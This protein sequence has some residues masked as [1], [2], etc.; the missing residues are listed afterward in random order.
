MRK[1][2]LLLLLLPLVFSCTTG[3]SQSDTEAKNI[4]KVIEGKKYYVHTVGKGETLYGISKR[5]AVEVKEIVFENPLTINGLKVGET[6]KIPVPIR[7]IDPMVLD[8]K[9]I[10][11]T[12]QPGETFYSL[13]RQYD[14]SIETIDLANPEIVGTIKSGATIRIPVLRKATSKASLLQEVLELMDTTGASSLVDS[15]LTDST[16]MVI[17]DSIVLKDT[18]QIALMLP[19]YLDKNDTLAMER[20]EGDPVK[21][22]QKSVIGLEFYQGVMLALDSL[23][24]QGFK[25]NV[26]IYDTERDTSKIKEFIRDPS[27]PFTDLLIGPLYRSNLS[28]IRSYAIENKIHM[29]SPFISTNKILIGNEYV[30][31]VKPAVQTNVEEIAR[32]IEDQFLVDNDIM[33]ETKN[34]ILVHNGDAGEKMLCELFKQKTAQLRK[35]NRDSTRALLEYREM[36]VVNYLDREMEA[37]EEALSLADS[38]ILVIL[39]RDQIFVSKIISGLHRKHEDYSMVLFGLPVWKHFRNL[40]SKQL[41]ELNVHIASADYIDYEDTAVVQ[42]ENSFFKKYHM[43][44][45]KYACEGFDVTYYF[46]Q[47]LKEYGCRFSSYLPEANIRSLKSFNNYRKI[48]IGSGYENK[49]VFILKYEDYDLVLKSGDIN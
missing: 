28:M 34:V 10:Y 8:G 49:R 39:S 23:R 41:M 16:L 11:H 17:K 19:L 12:V 7:V 47:V 43:N 42:F 1:F 9:Y 18:Y 31:K 33:F 15:S 5:Y 48:G 37:I 35:S 38:N 32:Y 2:R 6:I 45:S 26:T 13:S 24:R 40:E 30:C 21:A 25:A 22:Y 14:I 20:R 44:P 29:V 4:I 36:K 3:Y 27:L 46:L